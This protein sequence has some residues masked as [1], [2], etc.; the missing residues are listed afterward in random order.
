MVHYIIIMCV[1]HDA[2]MCT[3]SIFEVYTSIHRKMSYHLVFNALKYLKLSL[4]LTLVTVLP[5]TFLTTYFR[6]TGKCKLLWSCSAP[7]H[8]LST[9][10]M[11]FSLVLKQPPPP[12]EAVY[13]FICV[14]RRVAVARYQMISLVLASESF[15]SSRT[16]ASSS[17]TINKVAKSTVAWPCCCHQYQHLPLVIN[18]FLWGMNSPLTA[19]GDE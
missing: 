2:M 17:S 6:F 14:R 7:I 13:C 16:S 18:H 8:S 15:L 3:V 19:H 1:A 9:L 4:L 11:I 5:L 12:I 10:Y